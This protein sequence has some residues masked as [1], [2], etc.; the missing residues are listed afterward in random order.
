[1]HKIYRI[2]NHSTI[3][4]KQTL[5]KAI[6]ALNESIPTHPDAGGSKIRKET[7]TAMTKLATMS[8]TPWIVQKTLDSLLQHAENQSQLTRL[9]ALQHADNL[10]QSEQ[11]MFIPLEKDKNKEFAIYDI[12]EYFK[13]NNIPNVFSDSIIFGRSLSTKNGVKYK[14]DVSV[15]KK[16]I[17]HQ[18]VKFEFEQVYTVPLAGN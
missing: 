17:E 10:L 3:E 13:G 1:M 16:S 12:Y 5:G 2:Q 4:G 6:D 7:M 11:N 18:A 14:V 15:Y 9:H 8:E